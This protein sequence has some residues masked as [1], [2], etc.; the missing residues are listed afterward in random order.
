[1]ENA[2]D[3]PVFLYFLSLWHAGGQEKLKPHFTLG[4]LP[5]LGSE[6]HL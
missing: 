5:L 1:M 3:H 4:L 2:E 6:P